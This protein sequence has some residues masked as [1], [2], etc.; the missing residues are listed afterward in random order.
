MSDLEIIIMINNIILSTTHDTD[1][2]DV[3]EKLNELTDILREQ[4]NG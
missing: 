2:S 1:V 3:L 4:N